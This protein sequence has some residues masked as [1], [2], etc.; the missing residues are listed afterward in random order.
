MFGLMRFWISEIQISEVPA[1]ASSSKVLRPGTGEGGDDIDNELL[2]LLGSKITILKS[3]PR[4]FVIRG[5][6]YL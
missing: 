4:N 6:G 3:G 1:S 5:R 2:S